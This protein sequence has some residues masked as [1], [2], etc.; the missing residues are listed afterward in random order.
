[1]SWAKPCPLY[2]IILEENNVGN[3]VAALWL[4]SKAK[5]VFGFTSLLA[6][7]NFG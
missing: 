1:M 2:E 5:S 3:A 6:R 7:L 4:A